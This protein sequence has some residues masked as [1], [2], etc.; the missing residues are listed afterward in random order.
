MNTNHIKELSIQVNLN[1]LSFCIL[2][3]SE[4]CITYLDHL[5]FD[6]KLTPSSILEEI[7]KTLSSNTVF[8]EAFNSVNLIYQNE[9][10]TIVPQSL[11]DE[12]HK[13][14]YLKFNSKILQ[15]DF[16]E[17]DEIVINDS[18][19]VYVPYMNINNYIFETF[20]EFTFKHASTVLIDNLL[21]RFAKLETQEVFINVNSAHIEMVVVNH[22]ALQFYNYFEYQTVEDFIYYVL[23]SLEQLQFNPEEIVVNL[24]GDIEKDDALYTIAYKYIRHI[25]FY[26]PD[27]IFKIS[28]NKQLK[29]PYQHFIILNSF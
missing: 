23:F 16:I 26:T 24:T 27:Y 15:T 8:S 5:N 28:D 9:L 18:V 29:Q 4:N 1:G 7:K 10:A 22:G 2:N 12:L 17:H 3:R 19:V 13:A 20:G 14:D 6:K 25:Q 11:Y 21:Q